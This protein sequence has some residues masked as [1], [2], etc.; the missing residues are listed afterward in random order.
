M[1]DYLLRPFSFTLAIKQR[2]FIYLIISLILLYL[3]FVFLYQLARYPLPSYDEGAYLKVAKNFARNGVYADFSDGE[4]RYTG[5]VISMGPTV[6]LPITVLYKLLGVSIAGARL[7]IVAYALLVLWMF[8]L[9]GTRLHSRMLGIAMVFLAFMHP[10]LAIYSM[11][12]QVLSE[13]PGLFFLLMGIWLWA[14]AGDRRL[15]YLIG[16]GVFWGLACITKHQYAMIALP[17]LFAAFVLDLIWCK[18]RAWLKFIVPG[19]LA[20]LIYGAWTYFSV[21]YLGA[22]ERTTSQELTS[23]G[24]LAG[25]FY[26]NPDRLLGNALGMLNSYPPYIPIFIYT[27]I[28]LLRRSNQERTWRLLAVLQVAAVGSYILTK[29]WNTYSLPAH[30]LSVPIV[31]RL[32]CELSGDFHPFWRQLR[33]RAR[34]RKQALSSLALVIVIGLLTIAAARAGRAQLRVITWPSDVLE[35]LANFMNANVP[36]TSLVETTESI[37]GVLTNHRYHF[38]PSTIGVTSVVRAPGESPQLFYDFRDYVDPDYL[39]TTKNKLKTQPPETFEL[40]FSVKD[41]NVYRRKAEVRQNGSATDTPERV[42]QIATQNS[43]CAAP[44][45]P[46]VAENCQVGTNDWVVRQRK[47]DIEGFVSPVSAKNGDSVSLFVKTSAATFDVGIYRSGYY[48]GAGGRLITSVEAIRSTPQPACQS[49]I[50]TGLVSCGNWTSSYSLVI[51]DNWTT[52]VYI[53]KLTRQDTGGESYALLTVRDDARKAAVLFQQSLFTYHAYTSYDGKSLYQF[54][55]SGCP[56]TTDT[57]RAAKVSLLRPY[58]GSMPVNVNGDNSYFQVEYPLVRW[59]EA[60]GYDVSY[61]TTLDTHQAGKANAVNTLLGH[62]IFLSVGH[63]EYW[64]QEMRDAVTAA[65]DAGVHIGVFSSNTSYW[66]VRL[67]ADPWTGEPDSVIVNYKTTESGPPDPS[68]HATG[69]WRDPT[70]VNNPEN[71]LL[72][73]QYIGDNDSFYFPLRVTADAAK[74]RIY[75]HTGLQQMPP[76]TYLNIGEDIIGWEWDGVVDNGRTPTGLKILA[77]SPVF[78]MLLQDAGNFLNGNM[79]IASTNVTRY[80]TPGGAIVFVTGTNQWSWGLG[81]RSIELRKIEP[82]IAQIT[83]NILADMGVQ[84]AT[85]SDSLILDGQDRELPLDQTALHRAN[86]SSPLIANIQAKVEGKNITISWDTDVETIGQVWIGTTSEKLIYP[87]KPDPYRV[88]SRQHRFARG[89]VE[90]TTYYFKIAV[91]GKNGQLGVS[92]EQSIRT[93]DPS[94]LSGIRYKLNLGENTRLAR[95]WAQRNSPIALGALVAGVFVLMLVGYRIRIRGLH[96]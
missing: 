28:L 76:D 86:E 68:G 22:N 21:F 7:V 25:S 33:E 61:A 81:A 38:P 91:M 51:P 14:A 16:A 55:S 9:L 43:N 13:V 18:Q 30:A 2:W 80:T 50:H 73:V 32:L 26:F 63:D 64:T 5:A 87:Y 35:R 44:A 75:R 47:G 96:G 67:E 93:Q 53:F 71:G 23:M 89:F 42:R 78:G 72:G 66:R 4:N 11:G 48:G 27:A 49:D 79:G 59:L 39:L 17:G 31:A 24:S 40:I 90:G 74:D 65:R 92:P 15:V 29:G 70:G 69:T 56:T 6:L 52:G 85:P 84:P 20:A 8:F 77:A 62:K 1:V 46:I 19:V 12:R 95:C 10:G 82:Y 54:N 36:Q 3:G 60:Q 88:F 37:M 34:N 45:N 41:Y 57:K 94:I 58:S 83:Y